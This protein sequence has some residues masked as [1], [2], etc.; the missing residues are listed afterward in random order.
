VSQH[1]DGIE[2][3]KTMNDRLLA[4]IEREVL[5]WPGVSK[6]TG[7]GGR[8]RNGFWVPPATIF[9]FG[10]RHLGHVHHNEDGL[11][12]FSFPK[13]VREG[14]IR[15]GRAIPHPAFPESRTDASYQVR[16][17]KT[18]PG[19]GALQDQLRTG[20]RP[21]RAARRPHKCRRYPKGSNMTEDAT[22]TALVTGASR[23]LGLALARRL[24][25]DGWALIIDARGEEALEA[26]RAELAELTKVTAIVGNVMDPEHRRALAGAASDAAAWTRS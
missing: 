19:R 3:R 25:R 1:K 21:R 14:L 11:A 6:E 15:S 26:A 10:R 2:R 17:P 20:G 18:C 22:R 9:R 7:G 4:Q 24:A 8:G 16:A 5:G 12:D 23:G 13:E